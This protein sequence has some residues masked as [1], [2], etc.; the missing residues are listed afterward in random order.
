MTVIYSYIWHQ[1]RE[2]L[3]LKILDKNHPNSDNWSQ[4]VMSSSSK[5]HWS[6]TY[7]TLPRFCSCWLGCGES[8]RDFIYSREAPHHCFDWPWINIFKDLKPQGISFPSFHHK[9][10][11]FI[12][13]SSI[14]I[15]HI[16]NAEVWGMSQHISESLYCP[17][18]VCSWCLC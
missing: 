4:C 10:G 8:Y 16:N 14:S 5:Y 6:G 3:W 11:I 13:H 7:C 15:E 17:T 9:R 12:H 18:D 2:D 1:G